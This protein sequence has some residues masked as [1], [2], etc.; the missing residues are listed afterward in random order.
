ME[1]LNFLDEPGENN[2]DEGNEPEV[3]EDEM[4]EENDENDLADKELEKRVKKTEATTIEG[5]KKD[6]GYN[7]A[8]PTGQKK[9]LGPGRAAALELL[10]K[11]SE[12]KE[13]GGK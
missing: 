8:I 12:E 2:E 10:K 13:K 1:Q 7:P 4:K 9:P 3:E 11:F 6:L 5:V